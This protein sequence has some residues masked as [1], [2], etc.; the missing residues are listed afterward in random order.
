MSDFSCVAIALTVP[1][2]TITLE[3]VDEVLI[4]IVAPAAVITFEEC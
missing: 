4:E 3:A 1:A 2:A